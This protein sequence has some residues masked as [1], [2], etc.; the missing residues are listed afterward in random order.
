[1]KSDTPTFGKFFEILRYPTNLLKW[2]FF[3]QEKNTKSEINSKVRSQKSQKTFSLRY[4]FALNR[5]LDIGVLGKW[6]NRKKSL[7]K[8]I[9]HEIEQSSIFFETFEITF[10]KLPIKNQFWYIRDWRFH[11]SFKTS[12][13]FRLLFPWNVYSKMSEF[14]VKVNFHHSV[15]IWWFFVFQIFTWN[16]FRRP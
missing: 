5:I 3:Q 4:F 6:K 11:V 10:Q 2:L 15:K 1:M 7:S 9:S 12:I 16:Q 8:Y 14:S 13:H